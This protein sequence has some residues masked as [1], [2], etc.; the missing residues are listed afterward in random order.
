MHSVV[1]IFE[2][3]MHIRVVQAM[4]YTELHGIWLRHRHLIEEVLFTQG[5]GPLCVHQTPEPKRA[6]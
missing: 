6:P 5:S 1:E 4:L 2:S 3:Y